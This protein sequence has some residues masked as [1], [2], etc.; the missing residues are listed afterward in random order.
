MK[1]QGRE[2]VWMFSRRY[3]EWL[4]LRDT[5]SETKTWFS[6][7]SFCSSSV[8]KTKSRGHKTWL[9][10]LYFC[11]WRCE[12]FSWLI[13]VPQMKSEHHDYRSFLWV[14]IQPDHLLS[15]LELSASHF[16]LAT[17]A[18]LSFPL[19][20][21]QTCSQPFA[22]CTSNTQPFLSLQPSQ[23]LLSSQSLSYF[24]RP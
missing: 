16:R 13:Q 20:L 24:L 4:I 17:H 8:P 2:C 7:M 22:K 6:Y 9:P 15:I 19:S 21:H 3:W 12:R 1:L 11:I 5:K 23:D 14:I 18:Y 10:D